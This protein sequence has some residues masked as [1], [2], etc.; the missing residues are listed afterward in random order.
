MPICIEC[1]DLVS[2]TYCTIT[3]QGPICQHC[4][5][6]EK[7]PSNTFTAVKT[8]W[9]QDQLTS[10]PRYSPEPDDCCDLPPNSR[11]HA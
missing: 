9:E 5:P 7:K 3:A 8:G 10:R 6:M 1:G 2:I 11:G 4:A